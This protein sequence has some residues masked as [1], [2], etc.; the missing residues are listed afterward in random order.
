MIGEEIHYL[1]SSARE[2][3]LEHLFIG[4]LLK[5]LWCNGMHDVEVLRSEVDD[6]GYDLVIECNSFIRHV[7]L[8]STHRQGKA[9]RQKINI[10]IAAKP[11]G[12]V[13][14][15]LFDSKSLE[16]GPFRWLGG[17]PGQ[18]IPSLGNKIARH[19]KGNSEGKKLERPN[20][21]VINKGQ[22]REVASMTG[23]VRELFGDCAPAPGGA[24]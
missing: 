14:W 19:T 9:S 2:N 7:Q 12:C 18:P 1:H 10:K 23:L 20:I 21:R 16:L 22:F 6:C 5:T 17:T 15:M 11:G 8:K 3:V 13:V 4:E 24:A